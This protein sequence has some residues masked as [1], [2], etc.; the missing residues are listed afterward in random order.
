[1]M[2]WLV[3][4]VSLAALFATVKADCSDY[5]G[6]SC[7]TCNTNGDEDSLLGCWWCEDDRRCHDHGTELL[8]QCDSKEGYECEGLMEEYSPA[9]FLYHAGLCIVQG[10]V[11]TLQ[12]VPQLLSLLGTMSVGDMDA[13]CSNLVASIASDQGGCDATQL[14]AAMGP[15]AAECDMLFTAICVVAD[16]VP[17]PCEWLEDTTQK[18]AGKPPPCLHH[19]VVIWLQWRV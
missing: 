17:D 3:V 15:S 7:A 2:V 8:W 19:R 18:C 13:T 12:S 6:T 1:M 10:A 4:T 11:G 14:C 9:D 5:D 16:D